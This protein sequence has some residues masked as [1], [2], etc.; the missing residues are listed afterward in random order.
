VETDFIEL[1]E[2]DGG[3]AAT[4]AILSSPQMTELR[5]S[6]LLSGTLNAYSNWLRTNRPNSP[7]EAAMLLFAATQFAN[8]LLSITGALLIDPD[9]VDEGATGIVEYLSA[10]L[11][12]EIRT[13]K[14]IMDAI[15]GANEHDEETGPASGA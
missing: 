15:V 14:S 3:E 5:K 11:A 6:L 1:G 12:H 7:T 10:E 8:D 4:E 9:R 2:G 13:Q